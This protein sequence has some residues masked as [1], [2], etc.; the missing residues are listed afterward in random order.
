MLTVANYAKPVLLFVMGV[1]LAITLPRKLA[2]ALS[3]S[4]SDHTGSQHFGAT[5]SNR[6]SRAR[7][8]MLRTILLR[9]ALLLLLGILLNNGFQLGDWRLTGSLQMFGF[10][11]VAVAVLMVMTGTLPT[12]PELTSPLLAL[13]LCISPLNSALSLSLSVHFSLGQVLL[14]QLQYAPNML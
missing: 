6:R 10:A 7:H 14:S 11:Y 12:G 5:H 2:A 13:T 4:G 8:S 9:S 3:E 1:A